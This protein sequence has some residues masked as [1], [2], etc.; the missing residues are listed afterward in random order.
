[1]LAAS[2]NTTVRVIIKAISNTVV[3]IV[4]RAPIQQ[5]QLLSIEAA[6]VEEKTTTGEM[7]EL[8]R[9]KD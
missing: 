6:K 5:Q 3:V 1:M 2:I 4:T 8:M 9:L 7:V